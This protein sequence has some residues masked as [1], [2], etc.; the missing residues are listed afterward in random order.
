M[1]SSSPST[2]R[3]LRITLP[4][5]AES[6]NPHLQV[7]DHRYRIAAVEDVTVDVPHHHAAVS[8]VRT[9]RD[10][11]FMAAIGADMVVAIRA[12]VFHGAQRE[13]VLRDIGD[14]GRFIRSGREY[15][16]LRAE[17]TQ[18]IPLLFVRQ[19]W[20]L[21]HAGHLRQQ[22]GHLGLRLDRQRPAPNHF[23]FGLAKETADQYELANMPVNRGD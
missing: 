16:D 19:A 14:P 3:I 13:A 8:R 5:S 20:Q 17:A 9:R 1:C 21:R 23:V 18:R 15:T 4:A 6:R 2:K 22:I 12:D 11:P 10:R 7:L